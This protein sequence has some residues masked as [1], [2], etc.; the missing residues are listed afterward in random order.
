MSSA[1]SAIARAWAG[2]HPEVRAAGLYAPTNVKTTI[3][4]PIRCERTAN[5]TR[6]LNSCRSE[7]YGLLSRNWYYSPT[8][9][10]LK[11]CSPLEGDQ[12]GRA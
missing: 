2:Q 5:S 6:S 4:I 7:V 9:E 1:A 12:V 8:P 3:L 10:M 11:R